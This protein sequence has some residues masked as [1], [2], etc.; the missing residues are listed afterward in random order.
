VP[1]SYTLDATD[2]LKDYVIANA[3]VGKLDQSS[4]DIPDPVTPEG[5][6]PVEEEP[7]VEDVALP[8]G[9]NFATDTGTFFTNAYRDLSGAPGDG[10][11]M[12]HRVTGTAEIQ[13]GALSLT[14]SRVSIGNSTPAVNTSG[15]D[16][17]TTGVFDL[18]VPWQISFKVVSVGGDTGKY[19]QIYV[20]NNTAS[21]SNSI[22]GG[23]SKFH[24]ILLSELV[25][26]QS[27]TVTGLTA[28][29]SSFVTLRTESSA[30]VVVDD[31]LIEAVE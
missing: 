4:L 8:Y 11:P 23:A 22:W 15:S 29:D 1:Y 27:Y 26:G 18:S 14:G 19:F 10:T 28:S 25:E 9:E 5:E 24:Q 2:G 21:S 17:A 12:Y 13:T 6:V 7:T 31:V 3:G 30:T 16:S 20:D